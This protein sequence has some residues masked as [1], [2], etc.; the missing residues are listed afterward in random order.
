MRRRRPDLLG[1]GLLVLVDLHCHPAACRQNLH[2]FQDKNT[3]ITS[4]SLAQNRTRYKDAANV[5]A[6]DH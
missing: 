5:Y 3:R 6:F 2:L 1:R 4:S